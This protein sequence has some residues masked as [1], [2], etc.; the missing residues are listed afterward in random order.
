MYQKK[1]K[2]KRISGN[3]PVLSVA[4]LMVVTLMFTMLAVPVKTYAEEK[5]SER[6]QDAGSG[7]IKIRTFRFFFLSEPLKNPNP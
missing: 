3:R 6:N 7:I 4:V 1:E 2:N 5:A